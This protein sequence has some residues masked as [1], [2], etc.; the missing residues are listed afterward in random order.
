MKFIKLM[1]NYIEFLDNK[2]FN[3]NVNKLKIYNK[4]KDK[5]KCI[6]SSENKN[7][8]LDT[9]LNKLYLDFLEADKDLMKNKK[10]GLFKTEIKN[11]NY[12]KDIPKPEELL[13]SQFVTNSAIKKIH[14]ESN[15]YIKYNFSIKQ[16]SVTVNFITFNEDIGFHIEKYNNYIENIYIW[17][18]I[19]S[20]H[21]FNYCSKNLHIYIYLTDLKRMLPQSNVHIIGADNVNGGVSNICVKN[22]I[23]EI[24][25]YRKE[26]WF[27]VLIH[28]TFH[29]YGLDFSDLQIDSVKSNF[30]NLFPIKSDF[31]V[32][33]AYTEFWGEFINLCFISYITLKEND[34]VDNQEKFLQLLRELMYIEKS[35]SML[36]CVKILNHMGLEYEDLFTINKVSNIKRSNLYKE[37]TN[38]F[39][40]FIL[41]NI[42]MYFSEDFLIFNNKNNTSLLRFQKTNNNLQ[43]F[44]LFTEKYHNNKLFLQDMKKQ[45]KN[46]KNLLKTKQSN[47]LKYNLRMTICEFY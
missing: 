44:Y 40:Y 5:N 24:V 47:M 33:E 32:F 35:Y 46:Y 10:K 9:V 26:E 15:F 41:K 23:S 11:I 17:F 27:K 42:L 18:Y 20:Q 6:F 36:Q 3:Y 21:A 2:N 39:P 13:E 22:S 4:E 28:E 45:D 34:E 14:N 43:N 37:K 25:I 12:I 30:K 8:D 1:N 38:I 19:A 31:E 7:K 16:R 29:N